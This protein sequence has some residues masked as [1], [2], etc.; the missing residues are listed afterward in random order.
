MSEGLAGLQRL[1]KLHDGR[2][3]A[4]W[5]EHTAQAAEAAEDLLQLSRQGACGEVLHQDH[6]LASLGGSL[7]GGDSSV[8]T[9]GGSHW[10]PGGSK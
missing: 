3:A 9:M 6:G 10:P 1:Q 8:G 7:Q 5:Q 4:L 2:D